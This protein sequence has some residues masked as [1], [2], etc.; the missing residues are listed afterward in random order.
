MSDVSLD[1]PLRGREPEIARVRALLEYVRR[2]GSSLL[3]LNGPPGVGK[4]RLLR[5]CRSLAAGM[6]FHVTGGPSGPE[7][8]ARGAQQWARCRHTPVVR[9]GYPARRTSAARPVLMIA[10][11]T[12]HPAAE[13]AGAAGLRGDGHGAPV[14]WIVTRRPGDRGA[15]SMPAGPTAGAHTELVSLGP[16]PGPAAS[17]LAGDLL[18]VPPAASLGPLVRSA[19]GHPRLVVELLLGMLEEGSVRIADGAAHLVRDELPARLRARVAL[20]LEEYSGACRQL[21]RVAAV[22]GGELE[23]DVLAA[24]LR[25]SPSDLLPV[26]EEAYTTGMLGSDCGRTAFCHELARRVVAASVPASLRRA[27]REEADRVR[28]AAPVAAAEAPVGGGTPAGCAV[29]NE[30]QSHVVAL[31]R[32]GLTNRQI[33]SQLGMSPHT[34]NY[35]LRKLFTRFG[36]RSRIGLLRAVEEGRDAVPPVVSSGQ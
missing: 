17:Q 7:S 30:R 25:T 18:G 15:G 21:L 32:A 31:V 8:G 26:L 10:D 29:L 13:G 14:L 3:V 24:V 23:C 28:P 5:A 34:V 19:S 27:L 22:L 12:G 16:L 11:G 9:G 2:G 4:T 36:V 1:S 35:H 6:G 33:A 20:T